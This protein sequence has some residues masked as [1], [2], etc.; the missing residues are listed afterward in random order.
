MKNRN[1]ILLLIFIVAGVALF[2]MTGWFWGTPL[3]TSV[4]P[5]AVTMKFTTAVS[6]VCS[7]LLT[8][9]M[10]RSFEGKKNFAL[11]FLPIPCLIIALL[12]SSLLISL[13]IGIKTGVENLFVQENIQAM[14]TVYP[15]TP[16]LATIIN[17]IL[18]LSCGLVVMAESKGAKR[19]VKAIGLIVMSVG[20]VGAMGYMFNNPFLYY[21][22]PG[23]STAIAINT[24]ILFILIGIAFVL[25]GK[26][27]R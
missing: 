4:L 21:V 23:I 10:L 3:W 8:Y 20:V 18:I 22:I 2:V 12:M 16:S 27:E 9:L 19:Y 14:L 6:F 7:A 24:T 15:G 25:L 11:T 13:L 1:I 26:E 5:N 17:F